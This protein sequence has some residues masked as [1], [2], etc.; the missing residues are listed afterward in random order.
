MS[1]IRWFADLSLSDVPAVGGKNASLGEIH[2]ELAVLGVKVPN[3]FATTAD[4]YR[5]YLMANDLESR[6][7]AVADSVDIANS[8]DLTDG[9]AHIRSLIENGEFPDDFA[10]E[11]VRAYR[12]LSL[13][14]GYAAV[15]V[16]SSTTA[17]RISNT[18]LADRHESYLVARGSEEL[19]TAVR[20]AYAGH[21]TA[22]FINRR[23]G[24]GWRYADVALSVGVQQMVRSDLASSGV[25]FTLDARSGNPHMVTIYATWGFGGNLE[26]G[27]VSADEFYVFKPTMEYGARSIVRRVVGAKETMRRLDDPAHGVVETATP[28][29]LRERITLSDDE[30]LS[31]ARSGATIDAHFAEAHGLDMAVELEWAKDGISGELFIV[32]A[33]IGT[34]P[35]GANDSAA[36]TRAVRIAA[37]DRVD[38]E[39][40]ARH[41]SPA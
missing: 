16:R 31:L 15:V 33:D 36:H 32:Q 30:V 7:A 29:H 21:F 14:N 28:R 35:G 12:R 37:A 6:I 13:T 27:T 10:E 8:A 22:G 39:S 25:M 3:G 24:R 17:G 11:I 18:S 1:A 4:A 5:R 2:K 34:I 23:L 41:S 9:V 19:L 20:K 40:R 26:R 38:R